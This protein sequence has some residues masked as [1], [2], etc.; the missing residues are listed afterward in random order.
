MS[1][2]IRNKDWVFNAL[3]SACEFYSVSPS[4][5]TSY[6]QTSKRHESDDFEGRDE[7][8]RGGAS[9]CIMSIPL[10]SLFKDGLPFKTMVTDEFSGRVMRVDL[11]K[12]QSDRLSTVRGHLG[13]RSLQSLR[14]LLDDYA[15]RNSYGEEQKDIEEDER[16]LAKVRL[17]WLLS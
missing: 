3:W 17:Y 15:Q 6:D 7:K 8:V 4:I 5:A 13:D 11:S 2:S 16:F 1:T 14:I 12:V 10:T 9:G